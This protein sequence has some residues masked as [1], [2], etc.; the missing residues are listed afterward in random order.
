M[1]STDFI[2]LLPFAILSVTAIVVLLAAAF[3]RHHTVIV[4]LTVMGIVA[5][6]LTLPWLVR[7]APAQVTALLTVDR[8]AVGWMAILGTITLGVTLLAWDYWR[9]RNE[10]AEEF[11]VL[12][13]LALLGA[14]ILV[15]A[16]HFASFFLGLE[17][18]SVGLYALIAY[19]RTRRFALEA[20]LKYLVLAA[21]SSS[22][23]L[24]G[25][26]LLYAHVG[27][28]DFVHVAR[29]LSLDSDPRILAITGLALLTVGIGFKLAIVPFHLWT[30]DI[31]QGAP[32]PVTAFVATASKV[33][34]FAVFLRLFRQLHPESGSP[35][36][37]L[38]AVVAVLSM[39]VG[40]LLA[41]RQQNVKRL[42]AYSSISQLGYL[43]VAVLAGGQWADLAGFY[44]LA[45]YTVTTLAAFGIVALL[46]PED[47]EA[48]RIADYRGLA[49]RR[50]WLAAVLTI[51]MLSLAGIP[52]TAGFVGKLY[53]LGAG[54]ADGLWW[55]VL[56]LVVSSTI[57][58]YYYL[59]VVFVLFAATETVGEP[60]PSTPRRRAW[61][62]QLTIAVAGSLIVWL[63]IYPTP[64][65]TF[66][67]RTILQLG[68]R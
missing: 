37:V 17:I 6:L 8:Y 32:V 20:G 2:L 53:L 50:P 30:P 23:L 59:R 22:F 45:A 62:S 64:L 1:T 7:L 12:L 15:A 33:A 41:L 54:T 35:L 51:S 40:N 44:F 9:L 28:M 11:Y 38:I 31:Y 25:M 56:S 3:C 60:I 65:I 34:S 47:R 68:V 58:L 48:D 63:G 24:F 16:N 55:M 42:L 19:D 57:G 49:W 29:A 13:V 21:T 61:P 27:R 4:V 14:M 26:A 46:S 67:Q 10:R 66:F 18:L 43:L 39:F 5:A 52:F 36:L